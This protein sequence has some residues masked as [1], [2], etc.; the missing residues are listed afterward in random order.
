MVLNFGEKWTR[1][2]LSFAVAFRAGHV[3]LAEHSNGQVVRVGDHVFTSSGASES[4]WASGSYAA[5]R[6]DT[7]TSGKQV[8]GR[9]GDILADV[10]GAWASFCRRVGLL[11][12]C[13]FDTWVAAWL[14]LPCGWRG[15]FFG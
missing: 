14:G 7:W 8:V 9:V 10:P 6:G 15:D 2:E 1:G 11:G 3:A 12:W 13:G 5:L 4:K